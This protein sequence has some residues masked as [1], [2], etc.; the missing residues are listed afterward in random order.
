MEAL[1]DPLA[2]VFQCYRTVEGKFRYRRLPPLELCPGYG[3]QTCTV[4]TR[5]GV[6]C[7]RNLAVEEEDLWN[8]D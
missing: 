1:L 6:R 3:E 7:P 2:P 4:K 5:G 8:Q